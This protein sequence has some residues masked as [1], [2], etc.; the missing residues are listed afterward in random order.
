MPLGFLIDHII[1]KST[2]WTRKLTIMMD[3]QEL[4]DKKFREL[5]ADITNA[6]LA[7][8]TKRSRRKELAIRHS[9]QLI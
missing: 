3:T 2:T 8:K 1:E 7:E 9:P 5:F 4:S 6:A